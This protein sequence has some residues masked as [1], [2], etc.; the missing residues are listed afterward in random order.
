MLMIWTLRSEAALISRL[1][2]TSPDSLVVRASASGTVGRRF[3]HQLAIPKVIKMV[4]AAPLLKLA[5]KG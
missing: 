2:F 3:A 1:D 4:L 5:T